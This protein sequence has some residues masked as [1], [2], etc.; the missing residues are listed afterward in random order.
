MLQRRSDSYTSHLGD[1]TVRFHRPLPDE[2][3]DYASIETM[4]R[5]SS[6]SSFCNPNYDASASTFRPSS[7]VKMLNSPPDS[8]LEDRNENYELTTLSP[9]SPPTGSG[10]PKAVRPYALAL[11]APR[12][13]VANA[14]R[15]IPASRGSRASS[16]GRM[17]AGRQLEP[18][19]PVY[20]FVV[21]GK[22]HGQVTVFKRPISIWR[23]LLDCYA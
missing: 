17:E 13:P 3:S 6:A 7:A 10:A 8:L 14:R 9:L 18:S 1:A 15:P 20:M 19:P 22:E 2:T 23:L 16:A 21:G 5:L 11:N 12:R 4:N